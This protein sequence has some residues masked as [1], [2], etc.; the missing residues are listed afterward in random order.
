MEG[1]SI[2][3]SSAWMIRTTELFPKEETEKE[4][5]HLQI[6]FIERKKAFEIHKIC[7]NLINVYF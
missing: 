5:T 2:E 1:S 7:H 4:D 6:P 3:D